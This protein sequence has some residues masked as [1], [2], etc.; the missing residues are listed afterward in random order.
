[1]TNVLFNTTLSDVETRYKAFRVD[2]SARFA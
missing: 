2:S 1:V